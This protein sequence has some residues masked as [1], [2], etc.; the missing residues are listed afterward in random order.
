VRSAWT[1]GKLALV[2]VSAG[3][4]LGVASFLVVQLLPHPVNLLGTLGAPWLAVAFVVGASARSR[5]SSAIAGAAGMAA[6]VAAYYVARRVAH[7]DA[8][9]GLLIR[10]EVLRYLAIGLLAGAAFGVA[11]HAWRRGGFIRRGI[12]AGLLAGALAAEVIVLSVR[13]W[14]GP[15]LALAVIQGTAA[16]AVA[17]RLPGSRPARPVA[18]GI[19][20]ATAAL[21]AAVI[22]IAELP[23][24][25]FR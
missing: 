21:V 3:L 16:V 9:G 14:R 20:A 13:A 6:A 1:S 7:P 12:A 10:G 15:E 17:L 4:A 11:G 25:L 24:R 5:S 2:A 19:G 18:L 8:A 23:L 22:L